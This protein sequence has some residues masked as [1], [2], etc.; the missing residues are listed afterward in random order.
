[1]RCDVAD[2]HA[3]VAVGNGCGIKRTV[4]AWALENPCPIFVVGRD[5]HALDDRAN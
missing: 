2:D 3:D 4:G 5:A 1:L